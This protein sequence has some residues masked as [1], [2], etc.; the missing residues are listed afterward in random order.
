M[1]GRQWFIGETRTSEQLKVYF[2][3]WRPTS[4]C[5]TL[6]QANFAE[7]PVPLAPWRPHHPRDCGSAPGF[8]RAEKSAVF[9]KL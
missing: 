4:A 9:E 1:I 7:L 5:P 8:I 3:P 2:P 6:R